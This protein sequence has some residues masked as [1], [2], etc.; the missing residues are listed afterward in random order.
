MRE[1]LVSFKTAKLAK[2]KGFKW[3]TKFY[4]RQPVVTKRGTNI[5]IER[6]YK[7]FKKR[8]KYSSFTEISYPNEE[9]KAPS[10]SL[11]QK[12]LREVHKIDIYITGY[13][14]GYYPQLNNVPPAN[15]EG[16]KY[17]DRRWNMPPRE[18]NANFKNYEEALEKGLQEA[19]KLI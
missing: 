15:Q 7:I 11:L 14:F 1:E 10:Q 4:Y 9:F 19:L 2:T 3:K 12:W 6:D 18:E 13:G 17:I 16:V 8:E 5:K